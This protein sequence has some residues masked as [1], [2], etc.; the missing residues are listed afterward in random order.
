MTSLV[1]VGIIQCVICFWQDYDRQESADAEEWNLN[2]LQYDSLQ[3]YTQQNTAK[4][5][6][7]E[8]QLLQECLF[9]GQAL[10]WKMQTF[11][12]YQATLVLGLQVVHQ[13]IECVTIHCAEQ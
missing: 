7:E 9:S 6:F 3:P 8:T 10:A 12:G 2:K 4:S 1:H 11:Y 13:Q 5:C